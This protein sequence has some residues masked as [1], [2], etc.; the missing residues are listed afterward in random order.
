MQ[1]S[2]CRPCS[3][4]LSTVFVNCKEPKVL[5]Q[6]W[7]S[8]IEITLGAMINDS[9]VL[10]LGIAS[11]ILLLLPGISNTE[12]AIGHRI[13]DIVILSTVLAHTVL[14]TLKSIKKLMIITYNLAR[15]TNLSY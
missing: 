14:K 6:Y 7:L 4:T 3:F 10:A 12:D 13:N 2:F 8:V 11:V 5:F 9:S 1:T 15:V